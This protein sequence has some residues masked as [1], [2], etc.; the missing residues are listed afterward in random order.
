MFQRLAPGLVV[1]GYLLE[2]LARGVFA[3]RLDRNRRP[4][5]II[6]QRIHPLLKQR[7]PML[8]ARDDGGPH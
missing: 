5:K 3:L 6:E 8:H 2:A 4:F 1:I 7:Q